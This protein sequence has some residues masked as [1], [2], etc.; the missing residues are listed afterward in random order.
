ML[1]VS[2]AV[3]SSEAYIFCSIFLEAEVLEISDAYFSYFL[4]IMLNIIII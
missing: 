4:S 2:R 3:E 1:L